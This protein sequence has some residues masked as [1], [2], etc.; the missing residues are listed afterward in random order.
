LKAAGRQ[1][2]RPVDAAA[3]LARQEVSSASDL[4]LT[5]LALVALGHSVDALADR[6]EALR[7]PDGQI[8][9]LVSS[10]TWG[11][12]ALRAA[13][14]SPDAQTVGWLLRVQA[15]TGGWSWDPRGDADAD[16]T[17][18]TVQALRSAGV[19]GRSLAIRRAFAFLRRAQNRDGGYGQQP[20]R[21][22][23]AQTTAW[24]LQAFAAVGRAADRKARAYL[25]RLRRSDGSYR[26]SAQYVTTPLWVTAEVVP[27]L[28]DRPFPLG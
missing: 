10:T 23:N 25:A 18:A 8:G 27:A 3:F 24:V 4:E 5:A 6:I 26:Y 16:D 2:D 7:R 11:V 17:A 12:L 1:P 13:G 28:L 21:P 15:R 14:R 9:P 19:S 20:G 22:S